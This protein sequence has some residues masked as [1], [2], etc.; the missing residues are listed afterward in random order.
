MVCGWLVRKVVGSTPSSNPTVTQWALRG[1]HK[2]LSACT[3]S[4][5]RLVILL[6]VLA[7]LASASLG[8]TKGN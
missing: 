8:K 6:N 2:V 1:A 3:N 5:P 7:A 4:A